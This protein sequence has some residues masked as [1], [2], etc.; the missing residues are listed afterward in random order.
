VVFFI[1][2]PQA[3]MAGAAQEALL[4]WVHALS[5]TLPAGAAKAVNQ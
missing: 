2:H 1:N 5:K 3:G 4:E